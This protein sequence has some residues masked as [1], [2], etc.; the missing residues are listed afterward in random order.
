MARDL[1]HNHLRFIAQ[2]IAT[3]PRN[4]TAAY[5][6][7]Y[8]DASEPTARSSASKLMADPDI[9]AEID[10]REAQLR[11]ELD[12]KAADVVREIFQ[13]AT[14][15]PADLVVSYRG[16]CRHCHGIDHKFQRRPSEY[17]ADLARYLKANKDDPLGLGFDVA[18]GIGFSSKRDPHPDC[19]EC[20]GTGEAYEYFKD[21]RD[22]SPAARRLYD[23]LKRTKDGRLE[24][25]V[26]DRTPAL[27]L[28]AQYLGI[29][30]KSVELTGKGGGPIQ[31]AGAVVSL[32]GVDPQE[33]SQVYQ[34]LIGGF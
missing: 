7:V 8:P 18:G 4:A 19:P 24:M 3:T 15:D 1:T 34:Q 20:D 32:K 28:A 22:L 5:M 12:I 21:V 17:Q 10:K 23:G 25:K 31:T 14:A 29:S 2:Y 26:R 13:V 30:R 16:A 6:R 9:K 33:A 11:L 27:N